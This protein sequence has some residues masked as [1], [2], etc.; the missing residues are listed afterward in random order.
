[1]GDN[2]RSKE[3][4]DLGFERGKMFFTELEHGVV[5]GNW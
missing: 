1:M 4:H 5:I 3:A 2:S